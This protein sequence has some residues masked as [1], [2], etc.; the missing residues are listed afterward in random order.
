MIGKPN[1]NR[2]AI[3]P[4]GSAHV[5][6]KKGD[7]FVVDRSD[8]ETVMA[9]GWWLSNSGYAVA[10]RYRRGGGSHRIL[11]HRL[12]CPTSPDKPGVDHIDR[13]KLNNRRGNL[14]AC[15][16]ADNLKNAKGHRDSRT[17][18]KGV[19]R[20]Y[21]DRFRARVGGHLVGTFRTIEEAQSAV[22]SFRAAAHGEF[23]RHA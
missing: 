17:G 4:D 7:V 2:Y 10:G 1:T 13:D 22:I 8:L 21:N 3:Q 12:L 23:A 14:R 6:T 20:T 5:I 16:Q 18:I 11:M 19:S 15:T 9:Y